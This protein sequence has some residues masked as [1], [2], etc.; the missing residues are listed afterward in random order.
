MIII[1][2]KKPPSTPINFAPKAEKK[3]LPLFYPYLKLNLYLA[4]SLLKSMRLFRNDRS[5]HTLTLDIVLNHILRSSVRLE[6]LAT[7]HRVQYRSFLLVTIPNE[8]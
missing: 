8:P 3:I 1:I 4:Q 2:L 5:M 6:P 7:G